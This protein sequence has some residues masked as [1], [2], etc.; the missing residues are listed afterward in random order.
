VVERRL[1]L[2]TRLVWSGVDVSVSGKAD[3]R[4]TLHW[5]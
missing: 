3:R 4:A 2:L 1:T 5:Q